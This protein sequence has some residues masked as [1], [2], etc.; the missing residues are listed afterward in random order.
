MRDDFIT[1]ARR[2]LYEGMEEAKAQA[3]GD[4]LRQDFEKLDLKQISKKKEV[5]LILWRSAFPEDS[6]Q[7]QFATHELGKKKLYRNLRWSAVIALLGISASI[8]IS[9][10][11]PKM[12][13]PLEKPTIAHT[14]QETTKSQSPEHRSK[15]TSSLSLPGEERAKRT[16]DEQTEK[17]RK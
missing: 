7:Y 14:K 8:F 17:Q 3:A 11:K 16:E 5:Q 1:D 9:M 10:H 15:N 2:W 6:P 12:Q 4:K 13:A